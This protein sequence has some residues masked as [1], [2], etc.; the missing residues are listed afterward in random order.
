MARRKSRLII[1]DARLDKKLKKER[2]L[3][4]R[5]AR[6]R[7]AA[8]KI[9]KKEKESMAENID[10]VKKDVT[11]VTEGVNGVTEEVKDAVEKTGEE[12][13]VQVKNIET[14]VDVE[15]AVKEVI[16][17]NSGDSKMINALIER[18][19]KKL[20]KKERKEND[21]DIINAIQNDDMKVLA[22]L[23]MEVRDKNESKLNY[24]KA[25]VYFAMLTSLLALVLVV[26]VSM[27]VFKIL[28][29]INNIVNQAN[30][31]IDQANQAIGQAND[32]IVQA[33]TILTDVQPTIDNLNSVTNELASTDITGIVEDVDALVVSSEKN[34][35]EALQTVTEID[36][37][38]LNDA[39]S[40]LSAIVAP[41]AGMFRR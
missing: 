35:S 12:T 31:V 1:R 37:Q 18:N 16:V 28:P 5:A 30:I 34:M 4:E 24:T 27:A 13:A 23:L 33:N 6:K 17:N 22:A 3:M 11:E 10:E 2:A 36:I 32:A 19:S 29:E 41:L 9:T 39:I 7:A 38:S 8:N 20:S 21:A 14:N 26:C 40:D 15:E 25:Q